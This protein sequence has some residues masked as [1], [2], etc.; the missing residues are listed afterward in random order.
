MKIIWF[1]RRPDERGVD[2][3]RE[4]NERRDAYR[5]L[6]WKTNGN[7]LLV[8]GDFDTHKELAEIAKEDIPETIPDGA[9]SCQSGFVTQWFSHGFDVDTPEDMKDAIAKALH[10]EKNL[11]W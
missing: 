6:Y 8:A 2:F 4:F 5:F 11:G 3:N 9:G 1:G 7:S 10:V